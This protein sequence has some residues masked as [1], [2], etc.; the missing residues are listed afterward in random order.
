MSEDNVSG[1]D[2][3]AWLRT[4]DRTAPPDYSSFHVV[5][6]VLPVLGEPATTRT[7]DAVEDSEAVVEEIRDSLPGDAPGDWFWIVP[8]E[9]EPLPGALT[10][11]LER[12]R[13]DPDAAVVGALLIEPR[14]RG[15]GTLVSDWAQ[16]ISGSGRLRP[17]T[18]PGEL[19][20][21]QLEA[22]RALGVPAGG[23]L[24]R[25]DAWRFLDGFNDELPRSHQG[26]D[27]GWRANLAGYR[28]MA[29]PAAQVIDHS[30]YGDPAEDR[31]AGL[32]LVAGNTRPARRWL[33]SLRLV[34]VCLLSA[35]GLLLG[36]DPE[37]ASEE[38]RGLG[39]WLTGRRLRHSVTDRLASLPI[40]PAARQATHAMRP[41]R[42]AGLRRG[43][44]QVAGRLVEWTQTFTGRGSA[45]SL[46]EM[47]GDDFA[48]TADRRHRL[49]LA[50]TGLVVLGVA[51]LA[52]ARTAF[53]TG[54]LS[55]SQLL[56][57]PEAWTSL[58]SSY[59]APVPGSGDV[60]G[61]PWVGLAGLFSL[62]TLGRPEWLV[63]ATFVATVPLAWL[64]AFRLLRQLVADRR[65]AG[66][67]ALGYALGPV[68]IG[69]LNVGSF[70]LA[71]TSILLP[72]LAYSGWLW[73]SQGDW[74]WR[75]AGA[76]AFWLLLACALVPLFWVPAL[77]AAVLTG[78]SARRARAWAQW[79]L[80]LAA[81]L[82]L[83]VGPWGSTVLRYPGRLLTGA[84]P[85][86]AP[87]TTSEPWLVLVGHT[88]DASPP[89][90]ISIAFFAV[91]WF[92]AIA[93]AARHPGVSG[94]ALAGAGLAVVVAVVLTRLVVELPPGSWSRPQALEWQLLAV[95]A[96]VLAACAG[97]DGIATELQGRDL[98]LR[99]LTS[100]GT[101]LI[102]VLAML[103]GGVWWVIGGQTGLTRGAVGTVPAFVRN[104]QTS[105]TPGRTLALVATGD[106]V[107][108]ALLEDD[109]A[110]LG[111]GERGVAFGGDAAAKQ[112]AAS[113]AA[114]LVG[115]SAD[116]QLLP[117]LVTLGVTNVT[118]TGGSSTQRLAINNVPGLG[119]GTGDATQYVWPVPESA[120]AVV[121]GADDSRTPVGQGS[122]I[123]GGPTGRTLHLAEPPDPRWVV[124]VGATR[125][126][127]ATGGEPATRFAVGDASGPLN[128]RLDAG[129][130]WWVWVQLA[131]LLV[132]AVMAAPSVRRRNEAS[133]PRRAAGGAE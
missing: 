77:A 24:V 68:L 52:A 90:W 85:Q 110:R 47:T 18:E 115:D 61:A 64:M 38:V 27:F 56:A 91:L 70:G 30:P 94:R 31:A 15:A 2:P 23:M 133:G 9:V 95:A 25:G 4:V 7:R 75:R 92:A 123:E 50:V 74:S 71:A 102:C 10:A 105:A 16:T 54:S 72:M 36:K 12:V 125:L 28:V 60:S 132:L 84:E 113:V 35:L 39:R 43:A 11:L 69:G 3:W 58:M 67:G 51:A 13:I 49:P 32:A 111:D 88:L 104:A 96:L 55:G 65:L 21:G 98:G 129:S 121:V 57:A 128:Y 100:L 106:S 126:A 127:T 37:R 41:S 117:D 107:R 103:L 119:L 1:E 5:A 124:Q 19:Y 87:L 73:L 108:W 99:H 83:L 59:L 45:V 76:V 130:L 33:T 62:L 82:L 97:L 42:W 8:D 109:F 17:L 63:T 122:V 46:D 78:L 14:R 101:A 120:I 48:E 44:E 112:L 66:L 29:E 81:P 26:F 86:L 80:V 34:V 93:G 6:G 53:G 22:V 40:T 118:L 116:D 20:Q 79:A 131:G 89:L 114:R